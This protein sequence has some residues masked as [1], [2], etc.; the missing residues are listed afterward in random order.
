MSLRK[1]LVALVVMFAAGYGLGMAWERTARSSAARISQ[2]ALKM[3]GVYRVTHT[4]DRI[5]DPNSFQHVDIAVSRPVSAVSIAADIYKKM[6]D[7]E[8]KKVLVKVHYQ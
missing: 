1:L 4:C 8:R 7:T 6:T 3:D 5:D 2:E